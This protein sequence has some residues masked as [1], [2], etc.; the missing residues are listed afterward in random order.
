VLGHADRSEIEHDELQTINRLTTL[1]VSYLVAPRLQ[2]SATLPYV[3][4]SHQHIDTATGDLEQWD[5]GALATQ[6][7]RAATGSIN[8]RRRRPLNRSGSRPA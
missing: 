2:L 6:P 8:R 3:S 1:Q 5:F 7:C 4:R